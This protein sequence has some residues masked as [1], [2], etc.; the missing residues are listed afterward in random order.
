[1]SESKTA[2]ETQPAIDLQETVE[3]VEELRKKAAER[4]QFLDLAQRT[5]A[6]FENYQKRNNRERQE[7]RKFLAGE[8]VRDILPVLDNLERATAAAKQAGEKGPL[9]QGVSLVQQQFLD[10]LKRYGVTRIEAE[11]KPFDA[12][13]HQ[14]LVQHPTADK[15]PDTVLQVGVKW[16]AFGLD[17]GHAIA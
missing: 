7:E 4:D 11:G 9:V 8:F 3:N 15:P 14:A 10:F 16:L 1:M 13:L 5:R 12:N 17:A 2:P 6:D